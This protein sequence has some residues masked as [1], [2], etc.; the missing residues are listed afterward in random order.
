MKRGLSLLAATFVGVAL[1]QTAT[2][3][4]S[5]TKPGV[6]STVAN[7]TFF[8]DR[9]KAKHAHAVRKH[10]HHAHKHAH[11]KKAPHKK[12]KKH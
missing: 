8:V 9:K 7:A 6:E 5:L 4:P 3:A 12:H 1:A 11:L 2:A 10:K